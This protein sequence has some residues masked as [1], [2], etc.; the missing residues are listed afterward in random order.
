M[1][2]YQFVTDRLAVGGA[3]W[4]SENM[5]AAAR[6]GITHVVNLQQE[7][8]DRA[9]AEGTGVVILW[10]ACVD[11]WLPKPAWFFRDGVQFALEALKNPEARVL[12]HCA[13]GVHRGP[14]M[15]LAILRALGYGAERAKDMIAAARPQAE[16]PEVYLESVE[17]FIHEYHSDTDYNPATPYSENR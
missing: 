16:F 3:I 4:T 14:M 6:A 12:V 2:D 5:R 9:I 11:D 15:L 17:G 7:F 10:I 8:D 1:L 13:A